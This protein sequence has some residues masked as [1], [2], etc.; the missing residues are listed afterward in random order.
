MLHLLKQLTQQ[1]LHPDQLIRRRYVTFKG[2]LNSDRECHHLLAELEKI[3]YSGQP[4]DIARIRILFNDLSAS[5]E[6]MIDSL[7]DLA[8]GQYKDLPAYYKKIDFYGRF[9]LA[10]PK[11][12][13]SAPYVRGLLE[14]Y[15]ND[16]IVGGKGYHLSQLKGNMALPVPDGFI[17]ST[18][19]YHHIIEENGLREIIAR[20]LA[21][22]DPNSLTSLKETSDDLTSLIIGADIPEVIYNEIKETVNSISAGR[23]MAFAVRSSAVAED[24]ELSF[25]GQYLS[26]LNVNAEDIPDAYLQVVASKYSPEALLYRIYNGLDDATTPMA[27]VVLEMVKAQISG[28]ALT[29]GKDNDNHLR[30]RIHTVSGLADKLMSGE[31]R[32]DVTDIS[33][34]GGKVTTEPSGNRQ[35]LPEKLLGELASYAK[36][37]DSY[38]QSNQ[39]IE[40]SYDTD[41]K[42]YLVQSRTMSSPLPISEPKEQITPPELPLI[43]QGGETA[44]PGVAC[45]KLFI[46]EQLNPLPEI[47]SGAILVCD[48]TPPSL[49]ALLPKLGGVIAAS[50]SSADHFSSVAREFGVPVLLQTGEQIKKLDSASEVTLHADSRCVYKGRVDLPESLAEKKRLDPESNV[51]KIFKMVIDFTSPLSLLDPSAD[52]FKV[53]SCRSFHDIIR[54]V[55]E[56]G[57][58]AMF[59][60]NL[61]S[62]FRKPATVQLTSDIPLQ[63]FL[64]DVD[65]GINK[66][67]EDQLTVTIDHINCLPFTALWQGMSHPGVNWR[68]REHFDWATYDSIA[69]AGGVSGKNDSSLVSYCLMS[70]EYLN[71]NMRFGYHFTLLDSLAGESPEENYILMRFAGGGGTESGKD[72]RLNFITAVLEKL[73]FICEQSG[74]ILDARLMRYNSE[75]ICEKMISLGHLFGSVR[76]LDM[77]LNHEDEVPLLVDKFFN[78]IYD[79][80]NE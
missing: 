22:L 75:V 33:I 49:V 59:L 13:T 58:Q 52:S 11:V 12:D 38:Y 77:V 48:I 67:R 71:I 31:T 8:P 3:Y 23:D 66:E 60:K 25:A 21:E 6:A 50:G 4:V 15:E 34:S 17:L 27:V 37:I 32:A 10:E 54:F 40:W 68:D 2:L 42:L 26:L 74:E 55:H 57:V 80:S 18:T 46:T 7:H 35:Q 76:L 62:F 73:G 5:V 44:G 36:V 9:A 64:I 51:G 20:A 30:M 41:H 56:K 53:E 24:S 61:D 16:L 45:G 63:V 72:L 69:L 78:G 47:P 29:T 70:G 1:L 14:E 28:V 79:F 19:A 65:N 39:E 43:F